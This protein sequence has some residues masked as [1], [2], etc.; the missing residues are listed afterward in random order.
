MLTIYVEDFEHEILSPILS[1]NENIFELFIQKWIAV[2][3]LNVVKYIDIYDDTTFNHKMVKDL[4]VD[5]DMLISHANESEIYILQQIKELC[6]FT[7]SS[8]LTLVKYMF[9]NKNTIKI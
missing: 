3:P 8:L 7:L 6:F 9:Y 2:Y 4:L 1:D 5:I